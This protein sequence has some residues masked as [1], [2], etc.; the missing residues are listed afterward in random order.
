[1]GETTHLKLSKE[2]APHL[3]T[4]KH[5]LSPNILK[6]QSLRGLGFKVWCLGFRA[7]TQTSNPEVL[8]LYVY[9]CDDNDFRYFLLITTWDSVTINIT[10]IS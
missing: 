2:Q 4:L 3:E 8:K 5:E 10:S 6:A 1:M 7:K 9:S